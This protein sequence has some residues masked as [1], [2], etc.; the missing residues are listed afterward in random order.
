MLFFV[1][2]KESHKILKKIVIRMRMIK[3]RE[4]MGAIDLKKYLIRCYDADD[5]EEEENYGSNL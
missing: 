4:I 5:D 2:L 3:K 1:N